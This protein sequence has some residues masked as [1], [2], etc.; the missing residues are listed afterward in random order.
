VTE[1][2]AGVLGAAVGVH[3]RARCGSAA[4]AG[5]SPGPGSPGAAVPAPPTRH[6]TDPAAAQRRPQPGHPV[7][8]ARLTDPE[9]LRDLRDGLLPRPS[10][11]DR[12][13]PELRR[14]RCRHPG[15]LS[16]TILASEQVSDPAGQA[17]SLCVAG[18]GARQSA[19]RS[20]AGFCSSRRVSSGGSELWIAAR[21][22]SAW[23]RAASLIPYGV[24]RLKSTL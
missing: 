23:A 2:P 10:Q 21:A 9:I 15:H 11:L 17:P 16:E 12:P 4:S 5:P 20:A 8:Q 1:D 6:R 18:V 13:T 14:L 7:A 19:G 3:D 24:D 22:C